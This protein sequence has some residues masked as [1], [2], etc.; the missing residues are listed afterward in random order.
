MSLLWRGAQAATKL[1]EADALQGG[2]G[3]FAI[4][5]TRYRKTPEPSPGTLTSMR[6]VMALKSIFLGT[7]I[8][9]IGTL[10]ED[11]SVNLAPMSSARWLDVT[12]T[13]GIGTRDRTFAN[14]RREG[15]FILN[16][17]TVDQTVAVDRRARTT[18]SDSAADYTV[19]MGFRRERNKFEEAEL[20]AI[21]PDLVRRTRVVQFATQLGAKVRAIH[22]IGAREDNSVHMEAEAVREP[23]EEG[24]LDT[25]F[26]HHISPERWRPLN[27]RLRNSYD[28]SNGVHDSRLAQVL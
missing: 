13:L 9:S 18:D 24:R 12:G 16:L 1:A 15:E 26:R 7:T 2:K 10:N 5:T 8:V 6:N 4:L 22:S 28:L 20:T 14:L 23:V 3:L 17:V 19:A 27:I 11:E 21:A 25:G